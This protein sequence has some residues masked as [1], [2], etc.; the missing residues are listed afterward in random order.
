MRQKYM[1]KPQ[2]SKMS[3]A[4]KLK[5]TKRAVLTA[6]A[7]F[8]TILIIFPLIWIIPNAFKEKRDLFVLGEISF[9]P[10]EW[11]LDNFIKVF[12]TDVNGATFFGSMLSTFA[13][14]LLS[15]FFSLLVNMFAAYALARINFRGKKFI[16]PLLLFPMFIPGIT[17]MLTSIRVVNLLSMA[18][19]IFVL[20]V[21]G[22]A[23][24]Y[25]IFFFRQFY[26]D[27]PSN[28]EEAALI[29]GSS[30]IGIFF[31]IFLPMSI[32]PMIIIGAGTFMG[33]W[34][35]F[36]WPT[37][38]VDGAPGL[39]QMMQIIQTLS[40]SYAGDYGVVIAATLM[41]LVVPIIVFAIFQKKIVEGI[42]LTGTK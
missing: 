7:I 5:M 22:L 17:I 30:R 38:T 27:I 2:K 8:I 3:K 35:S 31:K 13:V 33:A 34:N 20:F 12:E 18:D 32:T 26:L 29:D 1:P 36:V 16:W 14:A 37:L 40:V 41:S 4:K 42:A 19:T 21:P 9:F 15:T 6:I 23:N 39:T 28:I 24:A 25:Q 10:E 11:T